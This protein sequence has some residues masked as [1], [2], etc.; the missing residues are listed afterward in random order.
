M[1]GRSG[2]TGVT[3]NAELLIS[4]CEIIPKPE[5]SGDYPQGLTWPTHGG[6]LVY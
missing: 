1:A 6:L 5:A 2:Q 4:A 3:N